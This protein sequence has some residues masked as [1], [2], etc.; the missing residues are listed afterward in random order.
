MRDNEPIQKEDYNSV[1]VSPKYRTRMSKE[2]EDTK[3]EFGITKKLR[4]AIN[5]KYEVVE[6]I[7][8]GSYGQ[9]S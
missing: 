9:V 2:K 6:I 5:K 8:N 1:P 4:M 3:D 7:G